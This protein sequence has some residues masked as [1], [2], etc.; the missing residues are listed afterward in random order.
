MYLHLAPMTTQ[1]T[2]CHRWISNRPHKDTY[3]VHETILYQFV[4]QKY[5]EILKIVALIIIVPCFS[6]S[7]CTSTLIPWPDKTPECLTWIPNRTH[8]D[9]CGVHETIL[10]QFSV[11]KYIEILKIVALISKFTCFILFNTY[12]HLAPT[13]TKDTWKSYGYPIDPTRAP[14]VYM[15]PF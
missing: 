15:I 13:T 6:L 5:L 2:G 11:H 9:I 1:S 10:D 7:T 8:K 14:G 12:L 4:V 3:G